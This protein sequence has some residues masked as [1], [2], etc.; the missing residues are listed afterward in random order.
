MFNIFS[1]EKKDDYIKQNLKCK[2]C[3]DILKVDLAKDLPL[4]ETSAISLGFHISRHGVTEDEL[5]N[6]F[7]PYYIITKNGGDI[8]LSCKWCN[9]K[10]VING[11]KINILNVSNIIKHTTQHLS[12]LDQCDMSDRFLGTYFII[13]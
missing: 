10:T 8:I 5:I 12:V 13:L 9:N 1:Q 4:K 3:N 11:K 7:N 6:L 2:K